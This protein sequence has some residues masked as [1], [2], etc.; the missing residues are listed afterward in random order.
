MWFLQQIKEL[1]NE[2]GLFKSR[3]SDHDKL[4]DY[5]KG[6][7]CQLIMVGLSGADYKKYK[8]IL[9]AKRRIAE[10]AMVVQGYQSGKTTYQLAGEFDC[11]HQTISNIL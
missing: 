2:N 1:Q 6:V 7:V 3:H 11:H 10:T 4:A 5:T 8:T 9:Q